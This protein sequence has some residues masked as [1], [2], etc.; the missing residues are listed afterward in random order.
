[1]SIPLLALY[2]V[3]RGVIFVT[4]LLLVGSQVAGRLFRQSLSTSP[5][6]RAVLDFQLRRLPVPLLA[7][8]VIA[9]TLKGLLQLLSFRDPGEPVTFDFVQAVL[10]SGTWGN[11]W[12]IQLGATAVTL[13]ALL[14]WHQRG[15]V[16]PGV[17]GVLTAIILWGQTGM[18]H[19]AS[20]TWPGPT[21]RLLDG[22]HLVGL[23]LWL[24]TLGVLTFAA[25][26]SLRGEQQLP[27][28]A[29]VVE[30]FS[31][32]AR[33]GVVLVVLSGLT[34]AIVY[35]GPIARIVQSTWGRLLLVKLGCMLGVLALGWYNWRIVTPAL[36]AAHP[37]ARMRLRRAVRLELLLGFAMLAI[38]T[39]L[40]V[41]ALPGEG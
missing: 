27:E 10:L 24:G 25:F 15:G 33:T 18:G 12:M 40:V 41:S 35:V 30:R 14:R 31:F 36:G 8:L 3:V 2:A 19:A 7:T 29:A 23:G 13:L 6:L 28:L 9:C 34:A 17:L 37:A 5:D 39:M 4:L 22:A 16:A 11:A 26:P 21:G 20:A 1:M 38:T 32:F